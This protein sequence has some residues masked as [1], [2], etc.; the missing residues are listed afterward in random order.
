[1]LSVIVWK[2]LSIVRDF[3]DCRFSEMDFIEDSLPTD[4]LVTYKFVEWREEWSPSFFP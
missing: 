3:W 4:S 1:M 2:L